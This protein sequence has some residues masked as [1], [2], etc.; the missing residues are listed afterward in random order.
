MNFP[1]PTPNKAMPS[2][3]P[4]KRPR[5]ISVDDG[6]W[7]VMVVPDVHSPSELVR[8]ALYNPV[9][10]QHMVS[11]KVDAATLTSVHPIATA[12]IGR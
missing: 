8:T 2:S 5:C 10:R 7:V 12:A 6:W 1:R 3:C 11:I 4:V 9:G